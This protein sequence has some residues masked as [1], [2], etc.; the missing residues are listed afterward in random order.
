MII[1]LVA[2][3]HLRPAPVVPRGPRRAGPGRRSG[4]RYFFRDGRGAD[5]EEPPNNW[6]SAFGG[7]GLD[8]GHRS[9]TAAP[10]QWYLHT[11]RPGAARPRL[12]ATTPS[13]RTSTTSCGSGSTAGSTGCG[14]TR[15]RPWPRCPGCPTPTTARRRGSRR[16]L[17]RQPALGRRRRARHLPP[18]AGASPTAYDGDRVFVAEAVV[19]GPERLS[20]Y[21]RPGRDAHGVQ[22]PLPQARR[23]SAGALRAGHRR[24]AS[25]SLAPVGAPATWVLT[26][27]DEIAAASPATAATTTSSRLRRPTAH[28]EAVRPRRSGTRR[29]RAAAL[30]MLALPGGA[31]IYQGEEL[32]LPEVEDLP[33][34]AAA[35]PDRGSAPGDTARPR[36]LP[37]AAA[38]VRATGRRSASPPDGV[39]P[40]LPQPA[41]GRR[42]TVEAQEPTRTRR[43]SLYRAAL[44]LRRDAARAGDDRLRWLAAAGTACW[45]STGGR[46]RLRREP[47]GPAGR[48]LG[49]ERCCWPV[50]RVP[51]TPARHRRLAVEARRGLILRLSSSATAAQA[52]PI[53]EPVLSEQPD[54]RRRHRG[55]GPPAAH[56]AA[57]GPGRRG[58]GRRPGQQA[59]RRR[60]HRARRGHPA[61]RRGAVPDPAAQHRRGVLLRRGRD[62]RVQ[63]DR[64]RR[65]PWSSCARRGGCTPPAGRSP[66][67]WCSAARSAT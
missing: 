44:R 29:A 16:R 53:E 65:S 22:L 17:G 28:G 67:A 6:I 61:A 35:G 58:A 26:S 39:Q 3:P 55:R 4:T 15:R 14:S 13:S 33:D 43:S 54:R 21:L 42:S 20:R 5:G 7:A 34:E 27:H 37:G 11:V 8:P 38:V 25:T 1:D 60:H 52:A 36:R 47:L 59:A 66:S 51:G 57:A 50:A 63:P 62:D 24:H 10:G 48:A 18:L 64:R 41:A 30:L 12:D 45:P 56:P 19:S 40:W 23:G 46:L 2:Q 9:R 32:G 31:Y 49:A